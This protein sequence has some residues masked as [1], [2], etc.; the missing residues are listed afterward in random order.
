VASKKVKD[1][2]KDVLKDKL[3]TDTGEALKNIFNF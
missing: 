2:L 1:K 3:G